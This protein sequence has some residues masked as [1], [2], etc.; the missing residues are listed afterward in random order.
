[1]QHRRWTHLPT[2][3][4]RRVRRLPP[5]SA[6]FS[7]HLRLPC[8]VP[9]NSKCQSGSQ[10]VWARVVID[11]LT[12]A[13]FDQQPVCRQVPLRP[14]P[15]DA[16]PCPHAGIARF[17]P[18]SLCSLLVGGG[19]LL[20]PPC[21]ASVASQLT[22]S[23]YLLCTSQLGP[24][25]CARASRT[26]PASTRRRHAPGMHQRHAA[27]AARRGASGAAPCRRARAAPPCVFACRRGLPGGSPSPLTWGP[28]A[29]WGNVC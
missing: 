16:L 21:L 25:G 2:H 29:V 26:L 6:S 13:L 19:H 24:A 1:M 10:S 14:M 11:G 15:H 28:T 18:P 23:S 4:P 5:S 20:A 27:A 3:P 22:S 17:R 9:P 8:H 12:L 7:S